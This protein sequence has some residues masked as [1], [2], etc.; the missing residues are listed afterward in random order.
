MIISEQEKNRIRTLHRNNSVIKEQGPPY[1]CPSGTMG[2]KMTPCPGTTYQGGITMPYGPWYTTCATLN[3]QIPTQANIGDIVTGAGGQITYEILD[4]LHRNPS[5]PT[6]QWQSSSCS[7]T[8]TTTPKYVTVELCDGTSF[9]SSNS[10]MNMLVD[11]NG[12]VREPVIGDEF[13]APLG[14]PGSVIVNVRVIQVGTATSVPP[15]TFPIVS[16]PTTTGCDATA[17]SGYNTWISNW[18]NGGAFNSQNT[19]QPCTHICKQINT[20][21][22]KLTNAGTTQANQLNCKIDEGNN[23]SQI[24]GCNC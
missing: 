19:N 18:T 9:G 13:E 11:D 2:L 20:W 17:W 1:T 24:H 7:P 4:L 5:N 6:S 22:N 10:L 8:S 12:T 14:G 3:G 15:M 16:C 21:T 23:Q